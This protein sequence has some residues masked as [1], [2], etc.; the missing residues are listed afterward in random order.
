M[1]ATELAALAANA[2]AVNDSDAALAV[3]DEMDPQFYSY[4]YRIVGTF[5]QGLVLLVGVLGNLMV[6]VVV[7]R[8]PSM[9]S[10]TNCYL[11]SLAVADCV[12]LLSSVP[13]ELVSYY[14]VGNQWLWGEL[15]CAGFV[16]CQNLGINASS[17]S[18][19]AFTV[20]R[21]IAI[22]QP[23]RSQ[24]LCTV[25]RAKRITAA[26]WAFAL[27]YCSPWLGLTTTRPL[28]YRK[29]CWSVKKAIY[30]ISPII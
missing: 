18:L 23:M 7:K 29:L 14:L 5:F 10:P 1:N 3:T 13:N 6:V 20:E 19:V 8:S 2:T 28:R 4:R 27:A 12:V 9:R 21:Y 16:F 26:V 30:L 15:G 24:S 11:V 22:C 17:L 25:A